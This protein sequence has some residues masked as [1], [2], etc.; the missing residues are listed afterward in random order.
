MRSRVTDHD[1]RTRHR[2]S[3]EPEADGIDE[4]PDQAS[5]EFPWQVTDDE[6]AA[7]DALG[8]EGVWKVGPT[9]SS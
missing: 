7:L 3:E 2:S 9:S 4:T 1:D 6:L 5:H 8:K